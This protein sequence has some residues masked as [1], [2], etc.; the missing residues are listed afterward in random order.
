M[1]LVVSLGCHTFLKHRKGEIE[2]MQ[3]KHFSRKSVQIYLKILVLILVPAYNKSLWVGTY[4]T[5]FVGQEMVNFPA[6]QKPDPKISQR[7]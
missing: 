3:F 7:A 5:V 6:P 4:M 1:F 2:H